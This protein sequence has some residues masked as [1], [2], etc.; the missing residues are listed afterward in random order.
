MKHHAL[1][2]LVWLSRPLMQQIEQAVET[3]LLNTGVTVRMRAVMEILHRNGPASVPD[4]AR[5]LHIQRQYV[6]VMVNDAIT[7]EMVEKK[8]NASHARSALISLTDTGNTL[9][10]Q[11]LKKEQGLLRDIAR[12]LPAEDIETA[13]AVTNTVLTRF[14]ALNVRPKP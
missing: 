14:Q 4:L 8:P 12:D 13:L 10:T 9:I 6:Q 11:V 7:A 5:Q 1:Y 2:E 3:G